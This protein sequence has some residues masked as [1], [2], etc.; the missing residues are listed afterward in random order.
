MRFL[1]PRSGWELAW[2]LWN[3]VWLVFCGLDFVIGQLQ[4]DN[5]DA[6]RVHQR[7][8]QAR[9]LVSSKR[10]LYLTILLVL[11]L[12]VMARGWED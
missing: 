3:W 8:E 12:G 4:E 5:Q 2:F 10:C 9:R 11:G 6:R 7:S 1:P